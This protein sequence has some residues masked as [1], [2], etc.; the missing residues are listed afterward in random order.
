MLSKGR[1]LGLDAVR[2]LCAITIMLCHYTWEMGLGPQNA[3]GTYGVYIFFILSGFALYYMY[4]TDGSSNMDTRSFYLARIFRIVP[5][6]AAVTLYCTFTAG[7]SDT[8]IVNG[9]LNTT[10][11]SGLTFPG[12][13]SIV[14]GGWSVGIEAVFYLMFPFLLIFRSALSTAV[15]FLVLLVISRFYVGATFNISPMRENNWLYYTQPVTFILYFVGGIFMAKAFQPSLA[16]PGTQWVRAASIVGLMLV[17]FLAPLILGTSREQLL[18]G[19]ISL[20]MIAASL[21][22]VWV[23]A[24]TRLDG[25]AARLATFLGEISFA[26]YLLHYPVFGIVKSA[27]PSAPILWVAVLSAPITVLLAKLVHDFY[28]QPMRSL[29]RFF[30]DSDRSEVQAGQVMT[31]SS[32]RKPATDGCDRSPD[33]T[34]SNSA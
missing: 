10:L 29:Q 22:I 14:S 15:L 11:L 1:L 2:G 24:N 7:P 5:L 18:S 4:G 23:A 28:E 12:Y 27:M 17:T 21:L 13:M 25:V 30:R 32:A 34:F 33:C 6:Y 20:V 3:A 19:P 31:S 26:L 16:V 9:L 8:N